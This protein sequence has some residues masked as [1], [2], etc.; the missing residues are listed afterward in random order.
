LAGKW[1]EVLNTDELAYG[2][3]GV[4]N[5]EIHAVD[6]SPTVLRVPPLATIWLKRI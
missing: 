2:G 4:T 6:G 5:G 1:V 3:S